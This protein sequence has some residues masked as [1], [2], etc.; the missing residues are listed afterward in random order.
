M[1]GAGLTVAHFIR[2]YAADKMRKHTHGFLF[3][4]QQEHSDNGKNEGIYEDGSSYYARLAEQV[5]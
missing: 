2:S 4:S 1:M 3:G 5:A